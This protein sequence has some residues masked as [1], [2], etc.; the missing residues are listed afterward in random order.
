MEMKSLTTNWPLHP[1]AWRC[2]S[3]V[4]ISALLSGCG[5][6]SSSTG[7]D[8]SPPP[9][10]ELQLEI[11]ITFPVA[12][13]SLEGV[14]Q[15]T[16]SGTISSI[17]GSPF[18]LGDIAEFQVNGIP[19]TVNTEVGRW[20]ANLPLPISD[21]LELRATLRSSAGQEIEESIPILNRPVQGSYRLVKLD[22]GGG[23]ALVYG[24]GQLRRVDLNSGAETLLFAGLANGDQEPATGIRVD[25][26][27]KSAYLLRWEPYVWS[28]DAFVVDLDASTAQTFGAMQWSE[29]R[30]YQGF[31]QDPVNSQLV[32]SY[33]AIDDELQEHHCFLATIPILGTVSSVIAETSIVSDFPGSPDVAFCAGAVVVD[34]AN[35]RVIVSADGSASPEWQFPPEE[36]YGLYA[37]DLATGVG[38]ILS[39][40]IDEFGPSLKTP[41]WMFLQGGATHVITVD[42]ERVMEVDVDSGK[43]SI[44]LDNINLP[45]GVT[46]ID[47]DETGNRLLI[48]EGMSELKYL[49]LSS[50]EYQDVLRVTPGNPVGAGAVFP[51]IIRWGLPVLDDVRNRLFIFQPQDGQIYQID[52]DTLERSKITPEPSIETHRPYAAVVDTETGYLYFEGGSGEIWR[53]DPENGSQV[54][55]T[56]NDTQ[57]GTLLYWVMGLSVDSQRGLLYA[58]GGV[59]HAN[60]K[61]GLVAIDMATGN[62][63]LIAEVPRGANFPPALQ[64]NIYD[65][66]NDRVIATTSGNDVVQID[67]SSGE[68]TYLYDGSD[69]EYGYTESLALDAATGRII[70]GLTA[71]A[72]KEM[73]ETRSLDV[74]TGTYEV[75][76][77]VPAGFAY[78]QERALFFVLN[79]VLR[80]G[81]S[82]QVFAIDHFGVNTAVV[83]RPN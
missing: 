28:T 78:D 13:S 81:I 80:N 43:R 56:S 63:R 64:K 25:P 79:D 70:F 35:N 62:R 76:S 59:A 47:Y 26:T 23:S 29:P 12:G 3:I 57:S 37:Y 42:D 9:V 36:E 4:I 7:G 75:L 66:E 51:D 27:G 16:V 20:S 61:A 72:T 48:A 40:A 77:E 45:E 83:A 1:I 68:V 31:D 2:A 52:L 32:F 19:A 67:V 8:V 58:S 44:V 21:S 6:G 60:S 49:D 5:G 30:F 46:D 41:K 39:P 55:V 71:V 34:T 14:N 82:G 33:R 73:A 11:E 24:T 17:G 69:G 54:L 18:T 15:T 10:G 53:L 74:E 38:S 22:A 50:G 65:S